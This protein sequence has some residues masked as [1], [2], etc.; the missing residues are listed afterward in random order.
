MYS[1]KKDLGQ[2]AL[3]AMLTAMAV[4]LRIAHIIPV[5]NVQ[6]VTDMLMIVTLVIGF[7]FGFAMA[8]L[9]MVISNIFLGFG[10]WTIPQIL[11][12]AICIL[13]VFFLAK[14]LPVKRHFL[15]QL[16]IAGLLGFEYGFF[17]SIGMAIFG[18]IPGFIAYWT[19]GL[20]FDAYHAI[21]NLIF[22]PI[23]YKPMQLGI[24]Y[25]ERRISK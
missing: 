14:I 23:L 9:V 8:I 2:L 21:G 25:Y 24:K 6:P 7:F 12:Y 16:I 15:L 13:T 1:I 22:Y 19:S 11:S 20:L 5:P 3:L 17:V 18:G 4:V 10:I